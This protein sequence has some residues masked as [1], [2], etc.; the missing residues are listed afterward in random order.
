MARTIQPT[1]RSINLFLIKPVACKLS[2]QRSSTQ[3]T[4]GFLSFHFKYIAGITEVMG[5]SVKTNTTSKSFPFALP[6]KYRSPLN[7]NERELSNKFFAPPDLRGRKG[8]L[9]TVTPEMKVSCIHP[10]AE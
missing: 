8:T 2:G 6:G 5:D 9:C 1:A 10:S 3:I 7:T 4:N